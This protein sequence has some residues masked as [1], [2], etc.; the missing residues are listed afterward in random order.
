[1]RQAAAKTGLS[2]SAI[3]NIIDGN[4]PLPE[5]IRK[6]AQ[7]FSGDSTAERLALEDRLLVL[8]GYRREELSQAA[9]LKIIPLLSPE[10]QHIVEGLVGE[11]AKIE[12]IEVE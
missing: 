6:L 12:G 5:T 2:H 3:R 8:T 7:G 11:L 4:R 10:H 9:Y 1:M